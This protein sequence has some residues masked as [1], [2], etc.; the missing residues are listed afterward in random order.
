M[1]RVVLTRAQVREFDRRASEVYGI[2][3]L[4]LMENAGR[5]VA[6]KL[7]A[8]GARGPIVVCCGKGNNG[9]DGFVIARHLD[10]HGLPVRVVLWADPAELTGDAKVNCQAVIKA[11][12]PL[13][14]GPDAPT[15]GRLETLLAGAEWIV[16]AL[17]GTGF[18]GELRPPLAA[19]IAALNAHPAPKLAVD[20]PSGLDAD[21]GAAAAPTICAQHTCTFVAP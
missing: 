12:I 5:G 19:A 10:G 3:S 14:F 2:P 8:L 15:P 13:A 7:R 9:G 21:T 18:R 6:D 20:L 11:G 1:P 4:V 17:L 16:D